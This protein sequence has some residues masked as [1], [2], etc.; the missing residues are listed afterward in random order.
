MK[1]L[2]SIRFIHVRIVKHC[3][4]YIE[5]KLTLPF[6]KYGWPNDQS[7]KGRS[8]HR[9][10][11]TICDINIAFR[12]NTHISVGKFRSQTAPSLLEGHLLGLPETSYHICSTLR[13]MSLVCVSLGQLWT[14]TIMYF[15]GLLD[16]LSIRVLWFKSWLK[17]SEKF[18][19]FLPHTL[20]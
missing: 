6:S 15:R 10:E 20:S 11:Q 8:Y 2:W 19:N 9:A 12:W 7:Q 1:C 16:Y 17:S 18:M 13:K 14:H 4:R 3:I 5:C